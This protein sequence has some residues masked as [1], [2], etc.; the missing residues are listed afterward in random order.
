M[1]ICH[2][3]MCGVIAGHGGHPRWPWRAIGLIAGVW[4]IA[5]VLCLP[6]RAAAPPPVRPLP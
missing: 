4:A 6:R 2:A 5:A 1:N 3:I